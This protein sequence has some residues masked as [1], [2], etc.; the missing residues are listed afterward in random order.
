MTPAPI[1]PPAAGSW[2]KGFM[3][4]IVFRLRP[5]T[6]AQYHKMIEI[7]VLAHGDPVELLEGWIVAKSPL[8]VINDPDAKADATA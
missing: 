4:R 6:V 3:D 1:G 8:W 2:S 7:G 5:I